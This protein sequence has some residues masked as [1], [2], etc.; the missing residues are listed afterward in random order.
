S[1]RTVL[2]TILLW[3]YFLSSA[4]V[5]F[6]I[7][8]A[9]RRVP[10]AAQLLQSARDPTRLAADGTS[11]SAPFDAKPAQERSKHARAS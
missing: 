10:S 2:Q 3:P 5:I 4:L 11:A 7:D 1:E 9:V 8:V 6:V